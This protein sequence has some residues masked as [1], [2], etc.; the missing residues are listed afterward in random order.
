MLAVGGRSLVGQA[1]GWV[2]FGFGD[3]LVCGS[4]PDDTTRVFVEAVDAPGVAGNIFGRFEA[5]GI[6]VGVKLY[7]LNQR[8]SMSW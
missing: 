2:A 5:R 4:L 3:T 6:S 7:R 8:E 1:G